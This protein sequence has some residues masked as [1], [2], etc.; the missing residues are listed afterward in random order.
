MT[1]MLSSK[2][3][4]CLY[5]KLE[6]PVTVADLLDRGTPLSD[7]ESFAL[8]IM[9]SEMTPD[10]A[11][12]SMACCMQIIASRLEEDPALTTSL[13][14]QSNFILDDYA[15][16]WLQHQSKPAD[17]M[18][19]DNWSVYM[20]E[21]LE[22]MSDL[23]MMCA[24][25][26]GVSSVVAAE[27]CTIMQDQAVAHAEALDSLLPLEIEAQI[28]SLTELVYGDNVIPFPNIRRA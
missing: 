18:A 28:E 15:P 1:A 8:T 11:L 9:L 7:D 27:I 2:E 4:A 12:I 22:A 20:Q 13:T 26:F 5:T 23:L 17:K 16:Y 19:C 25:I 6:A 21:D 14:L 24:D 3:L 10:Q